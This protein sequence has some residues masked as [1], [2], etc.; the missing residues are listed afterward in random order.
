M[1]AAIGNASGNAPTH[2]GGRGKVVR[3]AV[4]RLRPAAIPTKPSA[5]SVAVEGSGMVAIQASP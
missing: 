2:L 3:L 1:T 4:L 5:R